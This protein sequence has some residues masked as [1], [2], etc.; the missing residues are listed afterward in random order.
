AE[1]AAV[2][3]GEVAGLWVSRVLGPLVPRRYRPVAAA[4]IARALLE[5]ALQGPP[6]EHVIESERL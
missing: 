6:G 5:A 3:P 4:R 2:R 1:R